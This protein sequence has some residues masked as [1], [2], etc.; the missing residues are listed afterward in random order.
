MSIDH[1]IE[2]EQKERRKGMAFGAIFLIS[3]FVVVLV[4]GLALR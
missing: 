1:L 4:I 2:H 3:A